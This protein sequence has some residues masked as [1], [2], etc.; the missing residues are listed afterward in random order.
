[1]FDVPDSKTFLLGLVVGLLVGVSVGGAFTADAPE[2][3]P[4][5]GQPPWS[6]SSGGPSCFDGP[7]NDIGWL[8]VMANGRTWA[9]TMDATVVHPA[10]TEVEVNV[11]RR[12]PGSYEIAFETVEST[13][14]KAPSEEGCQLATNVNVATAL[15]E[16]RFSVTV[17]G[18]AI[19]SVDQEETVA[20]LYGLPNPIN[21]TR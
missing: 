10:G 20:N 9:A 1:M 5:G 18:R 7:R 15:E 13:P 3:A 21:A 12:P 4:N 17:N 2:P 19:R 14:E 16:P 6:Y 11:S 8:H